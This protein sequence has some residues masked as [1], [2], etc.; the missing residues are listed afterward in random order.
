[1]K[2]EKPNRKRIVDAIAIGLLVILCSPIM[3]L[4]MTLSSPSVSEAVMPSLGECDVYYQD[5]Y[6]ECTTWLNAYLINMGI[7]VGVQ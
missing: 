1:M 3:S 4:M 2:F 7:I 6:I 5:I